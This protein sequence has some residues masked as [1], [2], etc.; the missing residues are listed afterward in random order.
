M[1][2]LVLI[3]SYISVASFSRPINWPKNF[4]NKPYVDVRAYIPSGS[5][6]LTTPI[7]SC[8]A[9]LP[10]GGTCSLE[11]L[12]G[13]D[14]LIGSTINVPAKV[15]LKIGPMKITATNG[16]N[17]CMINLSGDG[18]EVYGM[19]FKSWFYVNN[20]NYN[21]RTICGR[22]DNLKVHD[23]R[24]TGPPHWYDES[25]LYL[26][27]AVYLGCSPNM[28]ECANGT[29]FKRSRVYSNYVESGQNG[30]VLANVDGG[31]VYNNT[32]EVADRT[33]SAQAPG[34]RG[35]FC[36]YKGL[37]DVMLNGCH[38]S[39]V[40]GNYF[41]DSKN[42]RMSNAGYDRTAQDV[43]TDPAYGRNAW[44]ANKVEKQVGAEALNTVVPFTLFAGN[45]IRASYALFGI[46]FYASNGYQSDYST[47]LE[48][49]I[50][51]KG[52][53]RNYYCI[54]ISN[55]NSN[56]NLVGMVIDKNICKTSSRGLIVSAE[57]SGIITGAIIQNNKVT[58]ADREGAIL[59]AG[60]GMRDTVVS[61]NLIRGAGIQIATGPSGT[62]VIG[63]DIRNAASH[64][65]IFQ[66]NSIP[67]KGGVVQG[68][69]VNGCGG[70]GV[71]FSPTVSGVAVR[72][73]TIVSAVKGKYLN[74][75]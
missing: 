2:R 42:W 73:N 22:A 43:G 10:D 13:S 15:S 5:T 19:G 48:N 70:Y 58:V 50:E 18:A 71:V 33:G 6:D 75:N 9:Q 35:D 59:I 4:T 36:P 72:D 46:G 55:Q 40:Q 44:I 8:I 23:L 74:S 30:V 32:F 21:I 52:G 17:T 60:R 3:F 11:N 51:V 39:L 45:V 49:T 65:I 63:N 34:C 1:I 28:K 24:V 56:G 69:M 47:A 27:N 61:R 41:T 29:R 68:N 20:D 7:N 12:T 54:S 62:Q 53:P 25:K 31:L 67:I 66:E 16:L 38:R 57:G 26:G 37:A 64:C 14:W